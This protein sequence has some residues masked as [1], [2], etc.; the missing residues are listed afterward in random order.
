MP[1]PR[2]ALSWT[3]LYKVSIGK[4]WLPIPRPCSLSEP[5]FDSRQNQFTLQTGISVAVLEVLDELKHRSW[6]TRTHFCVWHLQYRYG[7]LPVA[8]SVPSCQICSKSRLRHSDNPSKSPTCLAE[9]E[10]KERLSIWNQS[11]SSD[12]LSIFYI[13]Y[14]HQSWK[15]S[16]NI[17]SLD[18]LKFVCNMWLVCFLAVS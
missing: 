7:A 16:E 14:I 10:K 12:Q 18:K 2:R 6:V 3:V 13:Q 17:L 11:K 9:S 4:H 8:P 15:H 5:Q 1:V